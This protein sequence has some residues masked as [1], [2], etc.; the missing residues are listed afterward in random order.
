MNEIYWM[1]IVG[2]L[3]TALTVVWIVALIIVVVML[4]VLLVSEGDVIE[5]RDDAHTFFKWLKR[6]LSVV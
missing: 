3:S 4:F 5:D 2:N 1:T 6:L